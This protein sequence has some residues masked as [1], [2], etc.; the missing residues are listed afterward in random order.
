MLCANQLR[1][2]FS[3][4][5][6]VLMHRLRWLGLTGTQHANAQS[7]NIRLKLLTIGAR[8]Y[9]KVRKVWVSFSE[10]YPYASDFAQ[11]LANLRRRGAWAP[12]G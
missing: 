12:P 9:I 11:I 3:S 6:Y 10:A 1:L 4:F 7:T 8:I 2:Y 5:A